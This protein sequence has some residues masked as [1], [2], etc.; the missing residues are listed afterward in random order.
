MVPGVTGKYNTKLYPEKQHF[1]G[2]FHIFPLHSITK[3]NVTPIFGY[4]SW[5]HM[6][7]SLECFCQKKKLGAN[8]LLGL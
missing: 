1:S 2:F 8:P 4:F 3:K 7:V 5:S 6:A